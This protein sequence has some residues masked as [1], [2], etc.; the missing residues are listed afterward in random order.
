VESSVRFVA[1]GLAAPVILTPAAPGFCERIDDETQILFRHGLGAL[2][3]ERWSE[4]VA[5][6]AEAEKRQGDEGGRILR[7]GSHWYDYLPHY[8]LGEALFELGKYPAAFE[9]WQESLRQGKLRSEQRKVIRRSVERLDAGCE[10]WIGRLEAETA[11]IDGRL[12]E[13]AAD[14]APLPEGTGATE[15]LTLL[16]SELQ[17]A[18]NE[19]TERPPSRLCGS[20]GAGELELEVAVAQASGV[21]AAS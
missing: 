8:Y 20:P 3:F 19:L 14:A 13:L 17:E 1:W 16:E 9:E 11:W 10:R 6:F 5:F 15:A 4:A 7:Y 2:S 18:R 21:A 12:R